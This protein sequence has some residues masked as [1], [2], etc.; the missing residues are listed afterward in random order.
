MRSL[1]FRLARWLARKTAPP[2]MRNGAPNTLPF[3]DAYR[4]LRSPSPLDLLAELKNTA[5]ACA[6]LNAAVCAS[7]PPKLYAG[8][9]PGEQSP[10]SHTRPLSSVHR[11]ALVASGLP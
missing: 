4:R 8:T 2:A 11:A 6:S 7:F 5:Y 3:A 9:R 10:R 1:L